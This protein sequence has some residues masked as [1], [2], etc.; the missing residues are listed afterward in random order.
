MS[1]APQV[2][3][4]H[5]FKTTTINPPKYYRYRLNPIT[6]SL[7]DSTEPFSRLLARS[8]PTG[9]VESATILTAHAT[10]CHPR[11]TSQLMPEVLT[12]QPLQLLSMSAVQRAKRKT[13]ARINFDEEES[14]FPAK[15]KSKIEAEPAQFNGNTNGVSTRK[16]KTGMHGDGHRSACFME[17]GLLWTVS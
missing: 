7:L 2:Q 16:S 15:K 4:R 1:L 9:R 3:A 14:G 10:V 17:T 11:I 12:R 13:A 8:F 6:P 5:N